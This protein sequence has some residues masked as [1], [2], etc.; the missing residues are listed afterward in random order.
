MSSRSLGGIGIVVG[1]DADDFSKGLS[2]I[3][4]IMTMDVG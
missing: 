3:R 1:E 4:G 2:S